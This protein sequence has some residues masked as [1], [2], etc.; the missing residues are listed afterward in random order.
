MDWFPIGAFSPRPAEC[1]LRSGTGA[2]YQGRVVIA[3]LPLLVTIVIDQPVD[4]EGFK[5]GFFLH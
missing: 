4:E 1:F 5:A 3:V 2:W